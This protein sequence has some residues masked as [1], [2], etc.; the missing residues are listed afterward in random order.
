LGVREV[1]VVVVVV[2]EEGWGGVWVLGRE[3]R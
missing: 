2:V 1:V 3:G